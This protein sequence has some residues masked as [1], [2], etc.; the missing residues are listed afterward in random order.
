[1]YI[2]TLDMFSAIKRLGPKL[3]MIGEMV[4]D[5]KFYMVMLTVFILAFGVPSYSLMYGVQEFSFH[6]PRAI[7][8]LAYW[9]IFGEIE[10][11]GDIEKNYEINGYIVFILLIAYM[12]VAS[13]LLINLLIAMFRLD[14]YI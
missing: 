12:T 13:V 10:I 11:L 14:I 9:Q 4:N 7:I 2:R 8:N 3:V 6:T 5:M 1:W